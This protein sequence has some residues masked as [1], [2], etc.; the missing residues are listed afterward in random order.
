MAGVGARDYLDFEEALAV[1][2]AVRR[3]LLADFCPS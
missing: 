1:W 3:T 2:A